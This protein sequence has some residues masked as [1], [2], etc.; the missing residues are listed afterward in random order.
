MSLTSCSE[1]CLTSGSLLTISS[2]RPLTSELQQA[3]G[4]PLY[5]LILSLLGFQ[6]QQINALWLGGSWLLILQYY[7]FIRDC[8]QARDVHYIE[9]TTTFFSYLE[10]SSVIGNVSASLVTLLPQ[11][12]QTW[13]LMA[14]A[15]LTTCHE[16]KGHSLTSH[17]ERKTKPSW[18]SSWSLQVNVNCMRT[19]P[20]C[21]W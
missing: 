11:W 2:T 20:L 6:V 9:Y 13:S 14:A 19:R 3:N 4:V 12:T 8:L 15:N 17:G 21:I 5:H 7:S 1:R 16:V 10:D 18:R